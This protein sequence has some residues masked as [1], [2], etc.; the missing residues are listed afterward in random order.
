MSPSLRKRCP[1]SAHHYSA[2]L[3][4]LANRDYRHSCCAESVIPSSA[5]T[6]TAI[7]S[8]SAG[9]SGSSGAKGVTSPYSDDGGCKSSSQISSEIAELSGFNI[10]G[11][12]VLTAKTRLRLYLAFLS[13]GPGIARHLR[14]KQRYESGG[15][16]SP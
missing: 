2:A 5:G 1:A 7:P 4:H 6:E 13:Q 11:C 12:M 10:V 3:R 8:S 14:R 9:S 16:E 15:S